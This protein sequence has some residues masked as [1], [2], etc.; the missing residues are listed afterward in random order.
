MGNGR[1]SKMLLGDTKGELHSFDRGVGAIDEMG[2]RDCEFLSGRGDRYLVPLV[3][4][5]AVNL[6]FCS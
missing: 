3:V 5:G 1:E 2:C 6:I 4:N